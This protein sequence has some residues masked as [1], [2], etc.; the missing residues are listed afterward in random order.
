MTRQVRTPAVFLPLMS[1]P[2]RTPITPA[3]HSLDSAT[4]EKPPK[5]AR[6]FEGRLDAATTGSGRV[7]Q[8]VTGMCWTFVGCL[9]PFLGADLAAKW[10]FSQGQRGLRGSHLSKSGWE[11]AAL[12]PSSSVPLNPASLIH[13]GR[14]RGKS[15]AALQYRSRARW[16]GRERTRPLLP[17]GTPWEVGFHSVYFYGTHRLATE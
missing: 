17:A 5:S 12:Q 4:S 9:V 3:S 2:G 7:A 11:K 13:P 15:Q 16:S 6:G 10:V 8:R 14:S 1:H